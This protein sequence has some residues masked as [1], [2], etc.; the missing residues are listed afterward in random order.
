MVG[1]GV[2]GV[3]GGWNVLQLSFLLAGM[4]VPSGNQYRP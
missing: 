2:I 4:R 1:E 3:V